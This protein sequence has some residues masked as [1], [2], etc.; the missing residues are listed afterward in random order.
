MPDKPQPVTW[1]G[2]LQ[3]LA[4]KNLGPYTGVQFDKIVKFQFNGGGRRVTRTFRVIT[5]QAYNAMGLIGSECNGI[6]ILDDDHLL[7]V[8]DEHARANTGWF[9]V[10]RRQVE[11]FNKI[12]TKM[13]WN[14]FRDFCDNHPRSRSPLRLLPPNKES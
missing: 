9:G 5:Y 14:E 13:S 1:P 6:C 8:L 4:H 12:T 10:S 11:E 2:E 7:V 3:G